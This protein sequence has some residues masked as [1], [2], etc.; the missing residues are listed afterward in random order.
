MAD[1]PTRYP[2]ESAPAYQ[3][4]CAYFALGADRSCE[5]VAAKYH[6]NVS[7]MYRWYAAHDWKE[8]ARAYDEA[9]SKEAAAAT[10]ARY[11]ANLEDHRKRSAE[12]G[13]GL[14]TV[15]GKMLQR[16]NTEL[17]SLEINSNT[18]ALVSRALQAALDLEAHALGLEQ[19]LPD[20]RGR[21]DDGQ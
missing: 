4:A 6:K 13:K 9:L 16:L 14:F 11:L 8:R 19:L 12:A 15:A 21:D 3:A 10:T 2:T 18:L 1:Y 20:L 5:Q 7:L 17:P